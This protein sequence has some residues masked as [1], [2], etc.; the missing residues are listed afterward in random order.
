MAVRRIL[1]FAGFVFCFLSSFASATSIPI[2]GE[3][4]KGQPFFGCC[5]NGDFY[6]QGPGLLLEQGTPDGNNSIGACVLGELCNFSFTVGD[7]SAF[8]TFCTAFSSGSL[9]GKTAN[10]LD[11]NLIFTGSALYSGATT[12]TVPMTVTGSIVGYQLVN[13]N[14]NGYDCTLGPVQFSLNIVGQGVGTVSLNGIDNIN[15]IVMDFTGTATT[16]R[17]VPEPI[18]LV[19]TATGLVGIWIKRRLGPPTMR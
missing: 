4:Y 12:M 9:D 3:A 5:F 2:S 18:S 11:P 8:C 10:Y 15:G 17:V 7:A 19:L 13:C 1:I 16:A 14:A 6:I